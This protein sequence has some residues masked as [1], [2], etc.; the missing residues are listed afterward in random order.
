MGPQLVEPMGDSDGLAGFVTN[1]SVQCEVGLSVL[2]GFVFDA[3]QFVLVQGRF[4]A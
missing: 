3:A 2:C 1:H 4:G